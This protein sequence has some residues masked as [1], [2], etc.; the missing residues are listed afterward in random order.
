[1][2][3]AHSGLDHA[4]VTDTVDKRVTHIRDGGAPIHAAFL[5]HLQH[6]VLHRFL[7]IGI[8]IELCHDQLVAFNH[9]AGRK[10]DRQS[11]LLRMIFNQ[12]TDRMNAAVNRSAMVRAVAE[13]LPHGLFLVPGDMQCVTYQ[14]IHTGIPGRGD[15][16]NRNAEHGFHGVDI[17]GTA[18]PGHFIHHVQ[19]HY[20]GHA[21]FQ[22]LHGKIQTPLN[23]GYIHDV[24]DGHGLFIEHKIPG[25]QFFAGIRRHGIDA[26]KI[27]HQRIG[28]STDGAVLPVHRDTGEIAH[29]LVGTGQLIKKGGLSAVLI[30]HQS[31]C[32]SCTLGQRIP[33]AS[34]MELSFLA[35][36]RM[37][38][39][40]VTC[41]LSILP[42]RFPE[43]LHFNLFRVCQSQCQLI[44]VNPQF[45]GISK[46]CKLH[47]RHIGSRKHTHIQKML[48]EIPLAPDRRDNG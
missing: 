32:Q 26:G 29:M 31:K 22:K 18:V 35:E 12:M 33:T 14:L 11:C 21:H 3:T 44:P 16:H 43:R 23:A 17:H 25:Y 48:S 10:P 41:R 47:H 13:V 15:R 2:F 28:M 5:F 46:R 20:R 6:K 4:R 39:L 19:R 24:N 30:A 9:L 1:M 42:D 45:H 40:P 37:S 7:L 8:Q 27:C 34:G 36:A 38:T